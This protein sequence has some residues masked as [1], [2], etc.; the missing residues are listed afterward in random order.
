MDYL[1]RLT[2]QFVPI[3][4]TRYASD[5]THTSLVTTTAATAQQETP[6]TAEFEQLLTILSLHEDVDK[7]VDHVIEDDEVDD[8][9]KNYI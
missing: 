3:N 2:S 6:P 1:I 9:G 7:G 8:D 5:V 4:R